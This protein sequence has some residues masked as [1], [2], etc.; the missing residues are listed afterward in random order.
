[1]LDSREDVEVGECPD[2]AEKD[3]GLYRR[4]GGMQREGSEEGAHG[5]SR[6]GGRQRDPLEHKENNNTETYDPTVLST[7]QYRFT[8]DPGHSVALGFLFAGSQGR[9]QIY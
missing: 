9:N 1:M 4:I 3:N 6:K 7:A 5:V 2:D 8:Q